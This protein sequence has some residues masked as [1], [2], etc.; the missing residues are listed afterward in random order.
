MKLDLITSVY[1][2][3]YL[4]P[5]FLNHYQ[6]QV[7]RIIVLYNMASTDNTSKILNDFDDQNK[8]TIIPFSFED[9]L[10]D[11]V[12]K[13]WFNNC[14]SKSNADYVIA[15]DIDELIFPSLS[16][17]SSIKS[18]LERNKSD[19]YE[20][21]LFQMYPDAETEKKDIDCNSLIWEQRH[22]GIF[23]KDYQKPSIFKPQQWRVGIGNHFIYNAFNP[24]VRANKT[25]ILSRYF[26]GCHLNNVNLD[27]A[28]QR[29]LS[30]TNMSK[31]NIK[32]GYGIQY[33]D[34]TE[35]NIRDEFNNVKTT[36]LW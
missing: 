15:V 4:L 12:K 11:I 36:K 7:D 30:R 2:E 29:R 8:L 27:F 31:V 18:I 25:N 22:W 21:T 24:Q 13:D 19:Y 14:I 1:N 35:Q 28:I 9:G 6:N 10:N 17:H 34:V 20:C 3:E 32:N 23:E 16:F 5:I 26:Y 33:I